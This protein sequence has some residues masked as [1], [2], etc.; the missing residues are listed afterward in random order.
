MKKLIAPCVTDTDLSFFGEIA[1]LL[2]PVIDLEL[3]SA[4][5][6]DL[7]PYTAQLIWTGQP[8]PN[9][10]SYRLPAELKPTQ[11]SQAELMTLTW[12]ISHF[13]TSLNQPSLDQLPLH[14][15]LTNSTNQVTYHNGRPKD[16]FLPS[17]IDQAPVE[18]WIIQEIQ[19]RPDH[20]VHLL[21]PSLSFDQILMQSYQGLYQ[22]SQL[23]G[24]FQQVQDIKPLLASY[25][26][27]TAQ[28]IVG[29][30]DTV[31]GA[32]LKNDWFDDH[33]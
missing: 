15:A 28:T 31:S 16:P 25:L 18:D 7:S 33:F 11:L 29:W 13:I 21:L 5:P 6:S 30:S 23:T 20:T 10:P 9:L 8:F 14:I 3:V 17:D 1:E 22:G 24:V 19:T 2:S 4:C 27:E 26:Q 32:S 12:D